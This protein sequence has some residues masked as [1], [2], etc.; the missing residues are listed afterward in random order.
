MTDGPPEN[1]PPGWAAQQP[2]AYGAP[3]PGSWAAPGQQP[4]FPPP[5]PGYGPHQQMPYNPYGAPPAPKPGIIPLRPLTL[6]DMYNGAVAAI[7]ANPKATLGLAAVVVTVTQLVAF[8]IQAATAEATL[9]LLTI[10][11]STVTDDPDAILGSLAGLLGGAVLTLI[12]SVISMVVLTGILTSVVGRSVFGESISIGQAWRQTAGRV[13]PLLGLGLLQT[14]MVFGIIVVPFLLIGVMAGTFLGAGAV[15]LFFLLL[16]GGVIGA[17]FLYTKMSLAGAAI[18][19]ERIGVFAAIGRSFR[20][21][22][23]DFWRVFGIL[24]LT[25]IVAGL[26]QGAIGAPFQIAGTIIGGDAETLQ[27]VT[28]GFYL[29]MALA[30]VGAI[31]GGVLASPFSAAVNTLLYADRRMRAEAFDL[32]LQ[33]EALERQRGGM[34]TGPQDLW[35]PSYGSGYRPPGPWQP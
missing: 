16:V 10:N 2:P 28:S 9:N 21:V 7:R 23:G 32:V 13:L 20:L 27:E 25:A 3:G 35:H 31:I 22:R 26:V 33:T 29:S 4:P 34:P 11:E 1:P 14:L 15:V 18:V 17:V 24:L 8:A 30:T 19:L 6:G 12:V 5:P